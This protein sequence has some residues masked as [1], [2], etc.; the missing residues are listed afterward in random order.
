MGETRMWISLIILITSLVRSLPINPKIV[1]IF[2]VMNFG[3]ISV[4]CN[5]W[6]VEQL[7]I[8]FV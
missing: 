1:E 6:S 8:R 2:G 3:Y 4:E 5:Y 7:L